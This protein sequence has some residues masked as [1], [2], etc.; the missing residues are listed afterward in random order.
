LT[1][2]EPSIKNSEF[3]KTNPK[4]WCR[5]SQAKAIEAGRFKPSQKR[6]PQV[7]TRWRKYWSWDWAFTS[8]FLYV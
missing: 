1:R 2:H 3:D 5:R 4:A 7:E 8:Y 6:F